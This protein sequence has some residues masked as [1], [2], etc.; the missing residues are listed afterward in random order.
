MALVIRAVGRLPFQQ[1]GNRRLNTSPVVSGH[2]G[3]A[4]NRFA[5][6]PPQLHDTMPFG[7]GRC[8][9]A[10]PATIFSPGG[11]ETTGPEVC[12]V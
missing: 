8:A 1:F 3:T 11:I 7:C 12:R 4:W 5:A 6:A 2:A 9:D 10:F